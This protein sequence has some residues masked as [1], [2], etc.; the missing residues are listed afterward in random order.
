MGKKI[1]GICDSS[2]L[3][4]AESA[5]CGE[6]NADLK[7]DKFEW[8]LTDIKN[9]RVVTDGHIKDAPGKNQIAWLIEPYDLHPENYDVAQQ[10]IGDFDYVVT[11]D[12]RIRGNNVWRYCFGGTWIDTRS[13]GIHEKYKNVSMVMSSKTS[14]PGH[15]LRHEVATRLENKLDAIFGHGINAV[16]S[17]FTALANYRFSVVIESCRINDYF[18]EK[19]IDCFSLGTVPIYWGSPK[20]TSH[21]N[22]LGII[23]VNS[24][25]E[26]SYALN[27]ATEKNYNWRLKYIKENLNIA[28][29]YKVCEN[30]FDKIL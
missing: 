5:S 26:I 30:F 8:K 28:K 10:R 14:L 3:Q 1:V 6:Q 2:F 23:V 13:W 9:A 4:F 17:K 19:I 16:D 24:F 29:D 18:T 27:V 12:R 25:E 11:Y 7:P 20:I 15:R 21:F 22:D